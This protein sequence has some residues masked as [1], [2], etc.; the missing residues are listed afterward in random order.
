[1]VMRFHTFL[2]KTGITDRFPKYFWN[3]PEINAGR[4]I[5]LLSNLATKIGIIRVIT[6]WPFVI[7]RPV[8]Q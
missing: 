8:K 2:P 3:G 1:V 7:H 6:D 5:H 4:S